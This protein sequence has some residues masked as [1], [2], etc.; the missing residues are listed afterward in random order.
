M[1]HLDMLYTVEPHEPLYNEVLDITNN[2]L[3]PNKAILFFF[4]PFRVVGLTQIFGILKK[5]RSNN[6]VKPFFS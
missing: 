2:F 1:C 5:K 4:S 6:V 3:Y